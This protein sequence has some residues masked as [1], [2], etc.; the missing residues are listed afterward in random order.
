MKTV[1]LWS[2]SVEM[3][4]EVPDHFCVTKK[5]SKF[6]TSI[7]VGLEQRKIYRFFVGSCKTVSLRRGTKELL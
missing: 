6:G 1:V 2:D 7:V 4:C 3:K 5:A